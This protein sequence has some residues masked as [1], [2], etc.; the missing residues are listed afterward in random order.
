MDSKKDI[1]S[2]IN[3][4]NSIY[5]I[6]GSNYLLDLFENLA[7]DYQNGKL[8]EKTSQYLKSKFNMRETDIDNYIELVLRTNYFELREAFDSFE[9]GFIPNIIFDQFEEKLEKSN[10]EQV[11]I[12]ECEKHNGKIL[13]LIEE[14]K[15]IH[16][17]LT[18]ANKRLYDL[19]TFIFKDYSNVTATNASIYEYGFINTK[20]D[21]I[22][23][24]PVFGV[25]ERV[26]NES[27]I[28][29]QHDL[30][31]LENLLLHL[32]PNADLFIILTADFTFGGG[33]KQNLRKFI[34]DMYNIEEISELP[35]K[36]FHPYSGVKTYLMVF[37]TKALDEIILKKYKC[38]RF[39]K[40]GGCI[41]MKAIQEDLFFK[42]EFEEKSTW[43]ID[44]I[45]AENDEELQ[46]Y[47]SSQNKKIALNDFAEV[48]R[49]R[50]VSKKDPTGNIGVI[51]I[52]NLDELGIDYSSLDY[53]EEVE[54]KVS[55]YLLEDKDVLVSSRGTILKVAI[56]NE[57][58]FPCIPSSNLIVIRQN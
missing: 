23:A 48:F 19:S 52:S 42:S 17:T 13:E 2:Q 5:N 25:R 6:K 56:F 55:R 47:L 40:T 44:I 51:N 28:S 45:N 41:D 39:S 11:L 35:D 46:R 18:F 32:N 37:T 3:E 16:F 1:F 10:A 31:A 43:N 14:N 8:S 12:T 24:V 20:F 58:T 30:A 22:F 15:D 53:I 9:E 36:T 50:S 33:E 38:V 26:K 27:F 49:G 21:Y 7:F 4:I 57:Q 34:L 29:R 54:R